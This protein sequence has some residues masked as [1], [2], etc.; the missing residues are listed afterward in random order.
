[1][2]ASLDGCRWTAQGLSLDCTGVV[3]GLHWGCCWT[4]QGLLLDCT[5]WCISRNCVQ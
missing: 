1:M 5:Q 2:C 3:V 4:A